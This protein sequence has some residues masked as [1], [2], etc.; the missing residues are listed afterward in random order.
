MGKCPNFIFQP[1]AGA[2]SAKQFFTEIEKVTC[3]KT[4]YQLYVEIVKIL[5][6]IAAKLFI[7]PLP[8]T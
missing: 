1:L 4:K 2:K 6:T 3:F 8:Y 5:N 7:F